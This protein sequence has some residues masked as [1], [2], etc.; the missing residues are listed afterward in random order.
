MSLKNVSIV[1]SDEL[2][3][4]FCEFEPKKSLIYFQHSFDN[5]I[6]RKILLQLGTVHVVIILG[7]EVVVIPSDKMVSSVL[8]CNSLIVIP[9]QK[10]SLLIV[11]SNSNPSSFA[12]VSLSFSMFCFSLV[13]SF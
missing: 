6:K 8:L 11:P 3:T 10:S 12:S 1:S 2:N 13:H 7:N 9:Y 4:D 5:S